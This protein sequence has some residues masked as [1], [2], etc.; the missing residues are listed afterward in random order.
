MEVGTIANWKVEEGQ[1]FE[2]GD[3]VCEVE[4]DKATVDFDMTDE[5]VVAKILVQPGAEVSV[6][7]PIMVVVDDLKDVSL[8]GYGFRTPLVE[9]ALFIVVL[10]LSLLFDRQC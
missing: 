5:G 6:G 8:S 3:V 9:N 7:T 10:L 2:A 4:T 1:A